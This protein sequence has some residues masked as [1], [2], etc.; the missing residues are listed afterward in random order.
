ML[1]FDFF[2]L[3]SGQ[4]KEVSPLWLSRAR[5]SFQRASDGIKK[6]II[7]TD[8]NDKEACRILNDRIMRVR[9]IW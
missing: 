6:A 1:M 4:L 2:V 5:G 7:N 8:L 9:R 3:Q